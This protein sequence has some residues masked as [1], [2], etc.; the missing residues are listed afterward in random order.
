M[1][2]ME[3]NTNIIG[4]VNRCKCCPQEVLVKAYKSEKKFFTLEDYQL[5]LNKLPRWCSLEFCGYSEPFL[6]PLCSRMIRMSS[7]QGF[8]V[9]LLTSLTGFQEKDIPILQW[10]RVHYIR[11]HVPDTVHFLIDEDQWIERHKLF[12]Q[13][14]LQADYDHLA[15]EQVSPKIHDYLT[16]IGVPKILPMAYVTRCG[17]VEPASEKT[18]DLFCYRERWHRNGLL[19]NGDVQLCSMDFALE[20][21]IGNLF[22]QS[23]MEIYDEAERLMISADHSK[24]LCCRCEWAKP[25]NWYNPFGRPIV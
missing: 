19:P 4:C 3:I 10:C 13:I 24:M 6:N 9:R 16:G 5:C 25:A 17:S 2:G 15:M 8:H 12:Y 11:I 23:Y 22:E 18:G 7:Q 14:G 21:K 1:T 20:C